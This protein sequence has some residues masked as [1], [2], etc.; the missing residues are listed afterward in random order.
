MEAISFDVPIIG[1]DVGGTSEII[2]PE[3]G[4]LLSSN[5]SCRGIAKALLKIQRHKLHPRSFWERNFNADINYPQF[6]R[7]LF[8]L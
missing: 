5:P 1:T 7:D 3:T 2:T 4:I 8:N 6:I